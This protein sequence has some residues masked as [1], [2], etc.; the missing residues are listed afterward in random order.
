MKLVPPI[1]E[2]HYLGDGVYAYY[3]G[4]HHVLRTD[5]HIVFLD[6]DVTESFLK[7]VENFKAKIEQM[8][9]QKENK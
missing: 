8:N 9:K 4:Y 7:Y 6:P 3:D 1:N 5:A 2:Q